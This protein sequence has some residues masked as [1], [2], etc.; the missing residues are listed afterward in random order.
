MIPEKYWR[1]IRIWF[2]LIGAV[3]VGCA[4]LAIVAVPQIRSEATP[5]YTAAVTM[6]VTRL[7]SADGSVTYI[8]G[9]GEGELLAG[10]TS[11]IIN[12]G[13]SPQ[14]VREVSARLAD[15]GI[16]ID[17]TT[18]TR[19]LSFTEDP[20]LFR[21]VITA[22][23][24]GNDLAEAI[25]QAA[26]LQ[27][28]DDVTDEET[29]VAEQARNSLQL[30]QTSLQDNLQELYQERQV[31]LDSLGD[32][33][34]GEALRNL[35]ASGVSADLSLTYR[36]L[37]NDLA[38]I[39]SDPEL[40]LINAEILSLEG[41]LGEIASKQHRFSADSLGGSSVSIIDPVN[42]APLPVPEGMR[43]RDMAMMGMIAGLVLGWFLAVAADSIAFGE[44]KTASKQQPTFGATRAH[45][46]DS[47]A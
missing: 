17:Q 32:D 29:R 31:K 33:Q 23:A 3:A 39:A 16:V 41:Q 2:W 22:R 45:E 40:S 6:G 4:A 24:S 19:K 34:I 46:T 18:L 42:A 20:G 25:A 43:T 26:A 38:R 28:I 9:S 10:Y 15:D 36:A 11:S 7:V 27:M 47:R 35:I 30:Q 13:N 12:R 37:V 14:F 21:V 5:D 8:G 44:R 1:I